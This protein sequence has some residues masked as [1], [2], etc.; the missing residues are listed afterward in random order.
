MPGLARPVRAG[1]LALALLYAAGL[2]AW[3]V[4][5]PLF[6]DRWWWL[7][8]ANAFA[9]YLFLPL[10][11]LLPLALWLRDRALLACA[12]LACAIGLWAFG[13]LLLPRI[14][15][16]AEPSAPRLTV[17][18]SNVFG[19]NESYADV[20]RALREADADVLALQELNPRMAEHLTRALGDRYPHRVLAPLDGV[21]GIGVYARYPL[22]V[23][24][25]EMPSEHW[26]GG[27]Q[28]LEMDFAGERVTL[29]NIHALPP[30]DPSDGDAIEWRARERERQARMLADYAAEREAVGPVIVLGDLNATQRQRAYRILAERL[31]DAWLQGGTGPGHT[32][33][34]PG[35]LDVFPS[36]A[37]RFLR[38]AP[39][40]LMRI[41]M[42]FVSRRW[43]TERAWT[44]PWDGHSDH[45]PV[46]AVLRLG[47]GEG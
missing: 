10:L 14:G 18:S 6:G 41:D 8:Y 44:G 5:H 42:I 4:L 38:H 47:G 2:L 28:L 43:S 46:G 40:W 39:R 33:P 1:L 37:L 27:P 36:D 7:Y 31:D 35:A 11:L 32:W 20:E 30:G 26:C 13:G 17:L 25:R 12:A 3:A 15:G 21:C 19:F 45:R 34:G 24:E 9:L 16:P 23:L 29:M 22:S